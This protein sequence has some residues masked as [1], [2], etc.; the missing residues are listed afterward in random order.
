[1]MDFSVMIGLIMGVSQ[2]LK[3]TGL[4]PQVIPLLNV[5]VGIGLTT[6]YLPTFDLMVVVQQGLLLG[7]SASGV[8]D[9][10]MSFEKKY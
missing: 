8:Y 2:L 10:C 7:L 5:L 9:V 3:K 4:N 6:L 1:M